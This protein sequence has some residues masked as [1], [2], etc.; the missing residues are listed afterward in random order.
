[1]VG[2]TLLFRPGEQECSAHAPYTTFM[3]TALIRR[4]SG[5]PAFRIYGKT[6]REIAWRTI[7]IYATHRRNRN[8][9]WPLWRGTCTCWSAELVAVGWDFAV[10]VVSDPAA[11]QTSRDNP[12][13]VAGGG[14]TKLSERI[15]LGAPVVPQRV[16]ILAHEVGHTI[17]ALRLGLVYLPLVGALTLFGE[18]PHWWNR[19]ENEAS[20][21]G[22]FGGIIPGSV[23]DELQ[24]RTVSPS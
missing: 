20:V 19:F 18:G 9:S 24:Y 8:S 12:L 14:F 3:L 1:M 4:L 23:C 17:Q 15:K 16:E 21:E 5:P 7:D 13:M 22:Q 10:D 6:R 11:W 2:G